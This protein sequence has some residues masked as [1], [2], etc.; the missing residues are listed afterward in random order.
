MDN[1]IV[2]NRIATGRKAT[3]LSQ[4]QF[5]QKLCVSSQ[6][7]GKWE[8]GESLPDIFMLGK[9]GEAIGTTDLNYFLGKSPCTCD[10]CDCCRSLQ[11]E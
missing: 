11:N 9:I 4:A 3:N 5:A 8:R 10:A 1:K 2:G 6:A 7:V